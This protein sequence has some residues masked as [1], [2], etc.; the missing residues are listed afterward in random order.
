MVIAGS[1]PV[2]F[3]EPRRHIPR[4]PKIVFQ[5]QRLAF[6]LVLVLILSVPRVVLLDLGVRGP[7]RPNDREA[8]EGEEEESQG[9]P[10]VISSCLPCTIASRPPY[11]SNDTVRMAFRISMQS[12]FCESSL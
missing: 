3:L 2:A 9:S 7:D 11:A 4:T 12:F 8:G 1:I 5:L 6:E 10:E